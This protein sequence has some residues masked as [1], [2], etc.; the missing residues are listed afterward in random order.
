MVTSFAPRVP[1]SQTPEIIIKY[2]YVQTVVCCMPL[3]LEISSSSLFWDRTKTFFL[4]LIFR[5]LKATTPKAPY[6][7]ESLNVLQKYKTYELYE[8]F[9][10]N[11]PKLFKELNLAEGNG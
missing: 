8:K 5:L 1:D 3:E 11:G 4:L 7:F 10:D 2:N 9:R 6:N